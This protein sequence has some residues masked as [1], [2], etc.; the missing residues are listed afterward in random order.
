MKYI[1][2]IDILI[3]I[4]VMICFT[5]L[6][7]CSTNLV[8]SDKPVADFGTGKILVMPVKDMAAVYGENMNVR[9]PICGKVF[10]TG[11]TATLASRML[12]EQLFQI[13]K[14]KDDYCL[15]SPDLANGVISELL[16]ENKTGISERDLLIKTGSRV[17]AYAVMAGY[18]FRFRERIG[19]RYSVK[20]PAS[21]GFDFH[22]IRV[23][24][25]CIL[26][27]GNYNETQRA[28]SENILH[29][30]TFLKRKGEWITAE[31]MAREGLEKMFKSFQPVSGN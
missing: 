30:G 22:L 2:K 23:S 26:W 19:E 27:G 8:V 15:L 21:V 14:K 25:G 29:I 20:S 31:E 11:K 28:L 6:S 3:T 1:K 5:A 18:L 24:D 16:A 9:C 4:V 12:T 7:A 17:Q 13:L 10:M